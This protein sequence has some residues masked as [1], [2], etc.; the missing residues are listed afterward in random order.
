MQRRMNA[1]IPNVAKAAHVAR[2]RGRSCHYRL[3]PQPLTHA[4]P[5]GDAHPPRLLAR[6]EGQVAPATPGE[7]VA[8]N[9][10]Q[11]SYLCLALD[12]G[13]RSA[14]LRAGSAHTRSAC[15]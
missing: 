2:L 7:S 13:E 6:G 1:T 12:I 15:A 10:L 9:V 14:E 3:R 4:P 5:L 11:S 8:P